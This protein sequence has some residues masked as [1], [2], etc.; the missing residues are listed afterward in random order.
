MQ[1]K[2]FGPRLNASRRA[3]RATKITPKAE[4]VRIVEGTRPS[5]TGATLQTVEY[6]PD[7]PA[8]AALVFHH[9]LQEHCRRYD[10]VFSTMADAGIAVFTYDAF[11]HGKSGGDRALIS[12]FS[13]LVDDFAAAGT[14][15]ATNP[16]VSGLPRFIGGHSLGG[17]VA[18]TTCLRDQAAWNGLLISGPALDVE[19]TPVLR[20]QA[21]VGS[22]LAAL[23]PRARIVPATDPVNMNRD[24]ERVKEYV[25]DPLNTVGPVAV[26]TAN[27]SLQAFRALA[28]RRGEVTLPLYAHH[29][30]ADKVTSYPAT[31]AFVKGAA[32]TDK[33]MVPVEGGFH[34]V[35]FE[36]CG[37][38]L[39]QEMIKW[40][41][42]R[43]GGAAKM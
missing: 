35:L 26:R 22:L 30:T 20:V 18:I 19:W 39:T 2:N 12:K 15:A 28:K 11:G 1:L 32:S 43:S 34:E 40:M 27:E 31:K 14:A 7:G 16:A 23:V 17:L 5:V 6:L 37:P 36:E 4:M 29:G 21:A 8:R 9:G 38:E 25:E 10:S 24:P 42:E 13:D 3:P 41:L 33:T